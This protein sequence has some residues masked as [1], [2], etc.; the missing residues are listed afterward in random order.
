MKGMIVVTEL[1]DVKLRFSSGG[2]IKSRASCKARLT[3][4]QVVVVSGKVTSGNNTLGGLP[5]RFDRDRGSRIPRSVNL[6][7]TWHIDLETLK[8]TGDNK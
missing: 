1:Y 2:K 7:G 6:F 5:Y 4:T 3:K 8:R